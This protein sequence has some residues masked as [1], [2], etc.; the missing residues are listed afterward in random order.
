MASPAGAHGGSGGI[1]TVSKTL[2]DAQIKALPTTPVEVIPAAGASS[3]IVVVSSVWILDARGGAYAHFD[4]VDS[5]LATLQY[6][7][8]GS[9]AVDAYSEAAQG[10]FAD[11]SGQHVLALFL[12]TTTG[13]FSVGWAFELPSPR[14]VAIVAAMTNGTSGNLTGGNVANSLVIHAAYLT[15]SV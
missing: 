7:G 10:A 12:P 8:T 5:M 4:P 6:D 1:S 11:A 14:N 15:L 13:T 9:P 3:M 2:T